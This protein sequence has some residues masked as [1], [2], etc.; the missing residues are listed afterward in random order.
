MNKWVDTFVNKLAE[1]ADKAQPLRSEDLDD[2]TLGKPAQLALQ[3]GVQHVLP[4]VSAL[5]AAAM[6]ALPKSSFTRP[7]PTAASHTM[8]SRQF[9]AH[10][11]KP[12]GNPV[13][14]A[15]GAP[16]KDIK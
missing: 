16:A 11:A 1:R 2:T 9:L 3:K 4:G 15:A 10:A 12:N 7:L 8:K 14:Q 5:G 13:V 6:P